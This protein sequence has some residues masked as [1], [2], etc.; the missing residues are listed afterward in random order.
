MKN[1]YVIIH[2]INIILDLK[3]KDYKH[4]SEFI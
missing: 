4:K 3:T 2:F 1:V